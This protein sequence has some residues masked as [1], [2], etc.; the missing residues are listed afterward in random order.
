M[1]PL[2]DCER[3]VAAVERLWKLFGARRTARAEA[4]PLASMGIGFTSPPKLEERLAELPQCTDPIDRHFH[5]QNIVTE[6]YAKRSD[7]E[8]RRLC[9][10]TGM[11][12]L[13]EFPSMIEQLREGP[14]TSTLRTMRPEVAQ[15]LLEE[16]DFRA[17]LE[18]EA[19]NPRELPIVD[20][21]AK[22]ATVLAEDGKVD[23][24][25]GVC[26]T[27]AKLGLQDGT[28][29]GYLGRAERIAKKYHGG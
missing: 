10:E 19:S 3:G 17:S 5:M 24:A 4:Q 14:A 7:P 23:V 15:L 22:L 18:A 13:N 9:I 27:A 8:M 12:H 29:S 6:T 16:E 20:S 21:F 2:A 1:E 25:I 11:A 28:K 26:R